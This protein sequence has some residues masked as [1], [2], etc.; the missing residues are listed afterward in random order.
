MH[1]Y[2]NIFVNSNK[3]AP[4]KLIV[5]DMDQVLRSVKWRIIMWGN[6]FNYAEIFDDNNRLVKVIRN[7]EELKKLMVFM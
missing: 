4:Q 3:I 5:L 2:I 1:Y 6:D 7:M